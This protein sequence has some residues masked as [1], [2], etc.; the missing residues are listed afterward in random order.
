MGGVRWWWGV[1]GRGMRWW[2]GVDGRGEMVVGC[3]WE[4]VRCGGGM[5]QNR[6]RGKVMGRGGK[7]EEMEVG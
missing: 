2:W 3:R 7:E 5:T 6:R 4:G 1:D